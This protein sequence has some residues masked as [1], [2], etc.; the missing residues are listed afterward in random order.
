MHI[1]NISCLQLGLRLSSCCWLIEVIQCWRLVDGQDLPLDPQAAAKIKKRQIVT[2]ILGWEMFLFILQIQG[3]MFK[4]NEEHFG[5]KGFNKPAR[6]QNVLVTFPFSS[7][8]GRWRQIDQLPSLLEHRHG[9]FHT[10]FVQYTLSRTDSWFGNVWS[11]FSLENPGK[12]Y[13][14]SWYTSKGRLVG[15]LF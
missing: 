10:V 4:G 8:L 9:D 5:H 2:G 15:G 1:F 3:F 12:S 14:W 11:H 7:S 13:I 6:T